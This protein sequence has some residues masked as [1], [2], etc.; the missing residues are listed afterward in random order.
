MHCQWMDA[1][2]IQCSLYLLTVKHML[3]MNIVIY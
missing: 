1:S 2:R 3:Y